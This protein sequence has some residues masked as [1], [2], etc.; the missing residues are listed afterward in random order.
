MDYVV[1]EE[2]IN[3]LKKHI[4]NLIDYTLNSIREQSEDWGL[5]E[6]DEIEEIESI[7]K[8]V[9]DRIVPHSRLVVYAD[10]HQK[11]FRE[12]YDNVL[13]ELQYTLKDYFPAIV[14]HLNNIINSEGDILTFD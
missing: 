11:H 9:I 2:Q 10:I 7:D 4:Q 1:T 8:I 14:F 13:A 6:M 12:D 5:G 3:S